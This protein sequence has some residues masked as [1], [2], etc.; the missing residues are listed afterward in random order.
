MLAL[1]PNPLRAVARHENSY[2]EWLS[3]KRT[4]RSSKAVGS[5]ALQEQLTSLEQ[6]IQGGREGQ[7]V[8]MTEEEMEAEAIERH[9]AGYGAASGVEQE[10]V[11]AEG[12]EFVGY[13]DLGSKEVEVE[14]S[15]EGGGGR[16]EG[17]RPGDAA[18][19]NA[20]QLFQGEGGGEEGV[21]M[22]GGG[23]T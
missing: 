20:L 4:K 17:W 18:T 23:G 15:V 21:W 9:R 2:N 6:Q 22:G 13:G 16:V 1:I 10:E 7:G 5:Q 19:S 11:D 12:D 14:P 8:G 3:E